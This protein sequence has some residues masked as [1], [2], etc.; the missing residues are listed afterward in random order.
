MATSFL[1]LPALMLVKPSPLSLR[2]PNPMLS[3]NKCAPP[4]PHHR[5][6]KFDRKSGVED[7][8]SVVAFM[9]GIYRLLF[10]FNILPVLRE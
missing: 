9:K 7:I 4:P 8:V 2:N 10:K 3:P 1:A 5:Y 6:C